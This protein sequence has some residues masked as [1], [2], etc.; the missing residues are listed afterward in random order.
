MKY[1]LKYKTKSRYLGFVREYYKEFNDKFSIFHFIANN[2]M[3]EWQVYMKKN[4]SI[5]NLIK[6]DLFLPIGKQ[7]DY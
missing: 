5:S 1:I 2:Q 4:Y 6:K 7:Q 3:S